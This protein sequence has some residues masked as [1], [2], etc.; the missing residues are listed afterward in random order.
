[1]N[2]LKR[3]LYYDE[4]VKPITI[5]FN[6]YWISN[7]GR[8]FSGKKQVTYRTLNGVEYSC[9]VWKELK[10]FYTHRYKTVTLTDKGG[11]RKN[12]YVHKLI[13]VSFVGLYDTH[14]FKIVYKDRDTENCTLDNLKLDFKNK[15]RANLMRYTKQQHLLSALT[16]DTRATGTI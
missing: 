4:T 5:E 14:Y 3:L 9:T 16:D 13:Y 2:N 7:L 6:G 15:S 11:K 10:I 1:M 8:V 12:I